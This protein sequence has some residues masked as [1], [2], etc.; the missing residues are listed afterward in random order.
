L[1]SDSELALS[2]AKGSASVRG[3]LVLTERQLQL[4]RGKNPH[5]WK[6][7]RTG[8]RAQLSALDCSAYFTTGARATQMSPMM[9][10]MNIRARS[11]L[12][13]EPAPANSFHTKTPQIVPTIEEPWPSA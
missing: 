9:K 5:Q 12:V 11:R 3:D 6:S 2:T 8:A 7:L 13:L 10:N 4:R 1:V